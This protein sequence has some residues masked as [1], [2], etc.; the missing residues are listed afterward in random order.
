M[1]ANTFEGREKQNN[2]KLEKFIGI[3]AL[4]SGIGIVA[5]WAAYFATGK[6]MGIEPSGA[7]ISFHIAAEFAT[8]A[9]LIIAGAGMLAAKRWGRQFFFTG[10]GMLLYAVINSPGYYTDGGNLMLYVFGGTG[11]AAIAALALIMRL[12]CGKD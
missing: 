12:P 2:M 9:A 11:I 5:T 10:M 3:Y 4:L 1:H 7:G 8:A 6:V